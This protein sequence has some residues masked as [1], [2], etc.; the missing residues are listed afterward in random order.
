MRAR[1]RVLVVDDSALIRQM[2][3]QALSLDPRIEIVGRR[4]DGVDAIEKVR[5]LRPMS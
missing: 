2:L 4:K 1:I 5:A 3:T